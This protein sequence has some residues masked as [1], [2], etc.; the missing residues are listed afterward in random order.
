MCRTGEKTMNHIDELQGLI[1]RTEEAKRV[2]LAEGTCFAW[3]IYQDLYL[4]LGRQAFCPRKMQVCQQAMEAMV[5]LA[6]DA[7]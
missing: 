7:R 2:Y 5:G 3:I 6:V 4:A 1:A